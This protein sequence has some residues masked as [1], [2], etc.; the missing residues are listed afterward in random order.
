[1]IAL[2]SDVVATG[3]FSFDKPGCASNLSR[4]LAMELATVADKNKPVV[5]RMKARL[6]TS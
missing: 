5:R 1:L 4:S 6:L 3:G 2:E